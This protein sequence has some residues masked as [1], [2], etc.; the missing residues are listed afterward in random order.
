MAAI[1]VLRDVYRN[2]FDV[3]AAVNPYVLR[4]KGE[5]VKTQFSSITAE[6]EMKPGPI[7]PEP[8]RWTFEKADEIVSFAKEN[9]IHLRGHTLVWHA[10]TPLWFYEGA[11]REI[12]L[13]RMKEHMR[14]MFDR[15]AKDVI[16]WDVVNEAVEDKTDA[17]LRDSRYHQIIGDDLVVKSFE[18]AR[19]LLPEG[20]F[21]YNDYNEIMPEK[22]TKILAVL[23]MLNSA[24]HLADAVGLQCHWNIRDLDLDELRRSIDLYAAKGVHLQMTEL[25][26]SLYGSEDREIYDAGTPENLELQA[27]LYGKVFA[28]FREYRE[29]IDSVTLWGATD[30]ESWLQGFPVRGRPY[31]K[32]LLFDGDCQPKEAFWR[33]VQF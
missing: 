1:P 27:E 25:D 13:G 6:N 29:I 32:P 14:V 7:R 20:Y 31:N 11:D 33:V 26:I 8:D 15:Y 22:R 17:V 30:A 9:G 28:M 18:L 23:D 4:N 10:Q 24:G 5:L 3:G 19:E 2:Y 16:A 21:V 12:L